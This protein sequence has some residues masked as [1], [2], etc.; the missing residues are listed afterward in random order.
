MK[1]VMSRHLFRLGFLHPGAYPKKE[2]DVV[3]PDCHDATS[4]ESLLHLDRGRGL[5]LHLRY[6]RL[7][8]LDLVKDPGM[9]IRWDFFT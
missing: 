4:C 3:A 7:E 5:R 9:G 6:S 2:S 8:V 1:E